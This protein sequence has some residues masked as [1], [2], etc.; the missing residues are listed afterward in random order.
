MKL[1]PLV[2]LV[3]LGLFALAMIGLLV[4][5]FREAHAFAQDVLPEV[6]FETGEV[7]PEE[8]LEAPA[9]VSEE[10]SAFAF[11]EGEE[12]GSYELVD[13]KNPDSL[14]SEEPEEALPEVSWDQ[15][16]VASVPPVE[17]DF[18]ATVARAQ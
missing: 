6:D 2:I 18:G 11:E 3:V 12:G 1:L 5:S 8:K 9:T 14:L 17:P 10:P 16:E 7:V 13:S 15:L 4:A